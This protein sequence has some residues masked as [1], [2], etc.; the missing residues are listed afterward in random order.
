MRLRNRPG[1]TL[2]E[3]LVVIAIIAVLIALLL[4]AVQAAREAARR[5]QCTN[6]LKQIGLALHNY[7]ST[8]D[9]FPMGVSQYAPTNVFN[10]DNW[11]VHALL[12]GSLEQQAMYNACNFMLGNNDNTK[13][14]YF[15][16]ST[17]CNAKVATF[18]CPSDPYAGNPCDSNYY[19]CQGTTTLIGPSQ[20]TQGSNGLFT[21]YRSYGVRD[22]TDGTSNT[23]AF[24]ESLVSSIGVTGTATNAWRGNMVENVGGSGADQVLDVRDP[25]ATAYM[26]G[27]I[28]PRCDGAWTANSK[29]HGAR[30]YFWEV[31]AVGITLFNTVVTPNS[32]QHPWG[33]CRGSQST[34]P[35]NSTYSNAQSQHPGGVNTLMADG[36][37]KF[38]KD[39]VSQ[40]VWFALGTRSSGEVIDASSY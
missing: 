28:F 20:A 11:S 36:S 12:L 8:Q 1:F 3:L 27:T 9:V 35:D 25:T 6:N 14:G 10:W 22:A 37:V 23:I 4:P 7:H 40:N 2:I 31:G 39:S 15:A 24:S 38:V 21:Y 29:I 13:P 32:K 19:A 26:L 17:V 16:N 30:G 5:I 33:A 18:L 34:W